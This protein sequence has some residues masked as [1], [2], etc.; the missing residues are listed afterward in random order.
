M[1]FAEVVDRRDL[2]DRVPPL[3][4][5][6]FQRH[7]LPKTAPLRR[8]LLRGLVHRQALLRRHELD[9]LEAHIGELECQVAIELAAPILVPVLRMRWLSGGAVCGWLLRAARVSAAATRAA[10][11]AAA[12]PP[13]SAPPETALGD[14]DARPSFGGFWDEDTACAPLLGIARLLPRP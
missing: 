13:A 14:K 9:P 7:V 8:H 2:L 12:D 1:R 11:A 4:Q 10:A 3:D 5:P 6:C